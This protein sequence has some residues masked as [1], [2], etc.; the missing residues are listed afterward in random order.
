MAASL[1]IR[2]GRATSDA[3]GASR[4]GNG[5]AESRA[6]AEE[7]LAAFVEENLDAIRRRRYDPDAFA[8]AVWGTCSGRAASSSPWGAARPCGM[9]SP[10]SRP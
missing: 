7:M 6:E 4:A 10:G 2:A 3:Y 9:R 1:K 5:V 8:D